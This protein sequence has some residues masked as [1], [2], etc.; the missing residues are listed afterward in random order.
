MK[1]AAIKLGNPDE[2]LAAGSRVELISAKNGKFLSEA[3][4]RT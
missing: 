2:H 1:L 3:I 4:Q